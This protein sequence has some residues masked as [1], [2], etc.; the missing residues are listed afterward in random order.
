MNSIIVFICLFALASASPYRMSD[1][2]YRWACRDSGNR[3]CELRWAAEWGDVHK[4]S[5]LRQLPGFDVNAAV[6][7]DGGWTALMWASFYGKTEFVR[8]LIEDDKTIINKQSTSALI[9]PAG[10]TALD[11]ARGENQQAIVRLLE[12][13]L[14][15]RSTTS[16]T[17]IDSRSF[18]DYKVTCTG[19][20]ARVS[21]EVNARRGDPDLHVGLSK[22]SS[23][24]CSSS[25]SG[26]DSCT[27]N[28]QSRTFYVKVFAYSSLSDAK[29]VVRG[30]IKMNVEDV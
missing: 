26:S 24:L 19:A 22:G 25:T 5:E 23:S 16:I 18:K 17:S 12:E 3:V 14:G 30:S 7:S 4:L 10:S 20:C 2:D 9:Y 21:I 1:D 29:L 6:N 13:A 11:M 28:T 8:R 15:I 27:I